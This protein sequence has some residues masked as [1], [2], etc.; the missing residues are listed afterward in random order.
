VVIKE[1][2]TTRVPMLS[3][4]PVNNRIAGLRNQHGIKTVRSL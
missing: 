3:A 2:V 1:G 4:A